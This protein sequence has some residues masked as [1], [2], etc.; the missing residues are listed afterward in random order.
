MALDGA[1][2]APSNFTQ[3]YLRVMGRLWGACTLPFNLMPNPCCQASEMKGHPVKLHLKPL[4]V[5]SVLAVASLVAVAQP[6][7][8]PPPVQGKPHA[9]RMDP[10]KMQERM[11]QRQA[12]LKAKLQLSA[13][14]EAAWNTY[15][16]ALKPPA[17]MQRP[18]R[19]EREKRR[20]EFA[21]MTTPQR[22]DQMQAM[23]QRREAAMAQR[24]EATKG[25]YAALTPAQQKLFDASTLRGMGGPGHHGGPRHHQG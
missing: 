17:D 7:A 22:I 8:N 3:R 16:A 6:A 10:A 20:A 25:F 21:A 2:D 9:V 15:L 11:A 5:S 23:H 12:E 14:Q 4:L 1:S 18:S 24:A 19:E 13:G